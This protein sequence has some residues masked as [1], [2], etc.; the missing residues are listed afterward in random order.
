MVAHDSKHVEADAE[1][2]V[3]LLGLQQGVL[4]ASATCDTI[5]VSTL[6]RRRSVHSEAAP[7]ATEADAAPREVH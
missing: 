6:G 3:D 7:S 1:Q 4:A 2:R 5:T